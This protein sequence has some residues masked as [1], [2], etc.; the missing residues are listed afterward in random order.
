MLWLRRGGWGEEIERSQLERGAG[1]MGDERERHR[2]LTPSG[3]IAAMNI[4]QP[5]SSWSGHGTIER[6]CADCRMGVT[7][8][9]G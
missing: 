8:S 4:S 1:E 3:T 2:L 6:Q 9:I 7:P 5:E